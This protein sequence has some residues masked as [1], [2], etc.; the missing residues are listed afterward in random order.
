MNPRFERVR[1]GSVL[2]RV[3]DEVLVRDDTEYA[4]LTIRING[5]G[6]DIRDRVSGFEI[7][8]KRQFVARSGQLVLS[9][10]DARNGAF[11]ILPDHCNNAIVTGNF[12]AFDVRSE[13]LLP[14]F[15]EY[16]T[17][18]KSFLTFCIRAS[19]GTTNRR[20]LQEAAFL[21]QEIPL[22]SIDEQ[23]RI[24]KRFDTFAAVID[25][26][27]RLRKETANEVRALFASAAEA[28]LK[29]PR[30]ATAPLESVCAIITDG[31]HQT[32][33][34]VDDGAMFL[35]AQNVKPF[36]FMPEQHRKVSHDDFRIYTARN[37]PKLGDVLLT[38]VGAGIGEAAVVDQDLDFAIYVS[39][40]LIRPKKEMLLPE[41]L[42]HWLNSPIGREHS[43]S[44]TL[45]RGH[46]QGNLNLALLRSFP[47]PLPSIPEQ[48]RV[49]AELDAIRAHVHQIA[50]LH[51]E[52]AT[53]LNAMLPAILDKAFRG[54][55]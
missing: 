47:V 46:S 9:K 36:R 10:I 33:R 8:T 2:S 4:R 21:D 24:L 41:F 27:A 15:F 6:I 54:E 42:V 40:A 49:V 34:Y 51:A 23:R 13:R 11:G 52:T 5:R 17:R 14:K 26:A 55:F 43:R 45:G 1:L 7:G 30:W 44:K 38:R 25:E 16:F 28:A 29:S 31:T 39:V 12:W 48:K 18:T 3:K 53:E 32:P 22:P 20:Y 50:V 35:S 37:K 19:E